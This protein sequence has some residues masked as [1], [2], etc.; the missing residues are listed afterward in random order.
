MKYG[1]YVFDSRGKT[2]DSGIV[3][4]QLLDPAL[5]RFLMSRS[6]ESGGVQ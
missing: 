2:K 5:S 1:L 4:S 3:N 6:T